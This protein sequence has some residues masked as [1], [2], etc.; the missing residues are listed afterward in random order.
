MYNDFR[1]NFFVCLGNVN[2]GFGRLAVYVISFLLSSFSRL[3]P[4]L[5]ASPLLT[6]FLVQYS[7]SISEHSLSIRIDKRSP[8]GL[9]VGRPVLGDKIS[10]LL[11]LSYIIIYY[12]HTKINMQKRTKFGL[13]ICWFCNAGRETR[14]LQMLWEFLF[15]GAGFPRPQIAQKSY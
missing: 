1:H 5:T 6:L 15:V 13:F 10:H 11:F 2:C 4:S 14:P 9:S 8:L 12:C 7:E 3:I